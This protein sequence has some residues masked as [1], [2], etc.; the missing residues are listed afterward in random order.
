[1]EELSRLYR[2][3]FD[4][5]TGEINPQVR[6]ELH[7]RLLEDLEEL[8]Q[9]RRQVPRDSQEEVELDQEIRRRLLLEI[10]LIIDEYVIAKRR[11]EL[12]HW[13]SRYGE[14]EHYIRGFYYF[15]LGEQG[16]LQDYH[17]VEAAGRWLVPRNP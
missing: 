1:M 12:E 16:V 6:A 5:R 8:L 15:R 9:R 10:Q 17:L 3:V 14:L 7:R 2:Q 13:R 4:E 11:G